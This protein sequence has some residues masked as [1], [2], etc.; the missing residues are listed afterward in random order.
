MLAVDFRGRTE[1]HVL[2]DTEL[3]VVWVCHK[4]LY[5]RHADSSSLS[6][7]VRFPRA[8]S[9]IAGCGPNGTTEACKQDPQS[10]ILAIAKLH[11][12]RHAE[13]EREDCGWHL[14]RVARSS[15]QTAGCA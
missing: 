11:S 13:R 10:C 5:E 15:L 14:T 12:S 6:C 8:I 1:V 7:R 3:D 4:T 2:M 9:Y